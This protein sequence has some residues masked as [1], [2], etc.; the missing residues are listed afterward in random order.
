M[1]QDAILKLN[2]KPHTPFGVASFGIGCLAFLL[3][4]VAIYLSTFELSS[5][6]LVGFLGVS[7]A[8]LTIGGFGTGIIGE[9]NQELERLYAHLGIGMNGMMLIF[10]IF[11]VWFG[12]LA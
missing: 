7:S 3:A 11:V 9:T 5:E 10:H 12:F 2:Q 4:G 8:M 6:I 1:K